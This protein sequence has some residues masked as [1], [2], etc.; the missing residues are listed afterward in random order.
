MASALVLNIHSETPELRKIQKVAEIL[1]SGGVILYPTDTGFALGCELSNRE[2]IDKIRRIR[3]LQPH[4]ELTFLCSSLSNISEFAKV[5]NQA[6]KILKRL[7]PGPYTIILPAS[8]N[9]PKFAQDDKRSTAGIRVPE[10]DLC[11]TL[12]QY[13]ES[14]LISISA[15]N[16]D[17]D[18]D[19]Y[20]DFADSFFNKVD[21][22][23]KSDQYYFL[24]ESTVIDMTTDAFKIVRQGANIEKA[25]EFINNDEI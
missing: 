21:L 2:A 10:N 12:L 9:V 11:Q 13:L 24:G 6:Y 17:V 19:D 18:Y 15:K 5:S 20:D 22:I 4:K 8:K 25:L 1:K 14:P 7:I 3:N 23:I 16:D